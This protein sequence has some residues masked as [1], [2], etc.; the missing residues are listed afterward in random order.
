MF[1]TPTPTS[2]ADVVSP[3]AAEV[4]QYQTAFR[5][6]AKGGSDI[7]A[8]RAQ[9]FLARSQLPEADLQHVWQTAVP[10]KERAAARVGQPRQIA[11]GRGARGRASRRAGAHMWPSPLLS[12]A[13]R[14][15]EASSLFARSR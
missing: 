12:S 3:T 9:R 7:S 2:A 4:D 10:Q 15:N 14:M 1:S 6:L 11:E 5:Q 13:S 8:S